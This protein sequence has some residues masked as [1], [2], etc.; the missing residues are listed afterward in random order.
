MKSIAVYTDARYLP[1]HKDRKIPLDIKNFIQE[2]DYRLVK[3]ASRLTGA[4][5]EDTIL[6]TWNYIIEEY[7]YVSDPHNVKYTDFLQFPFETLHLKCGDCEDTTFLFVSLCRANGISEKNIFACIG[8]IFDSGEY[9]G[10]SFGLYV[11]NGREYI[12]ETTLKNM[13]DK[14]WEYNKR[15]RD[16]YLIYYLFNDKECY[17]YD[18]VN[19]YTWCN[20]YEVA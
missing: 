5:E 12:I 7:E 14:L 10:H 16:K 11:N 8:G 15:L 18:G 13:Q 20:F 19:Y 4:T 1:S 17:K 3:L 9:S 2:N 6:N